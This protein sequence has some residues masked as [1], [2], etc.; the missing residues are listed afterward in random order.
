MTKRKPKDDSG[1]WTPIK[2]PNPTEGDEE[3][4]RVAPW[5][6]K[7]QS[8]TI[9]DHERYLMLAD[10]ALGKGKQRKSKG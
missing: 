7:T 5:P 10:E 4:P 3:G 9:P 8:D 1:V 2:R 6:K